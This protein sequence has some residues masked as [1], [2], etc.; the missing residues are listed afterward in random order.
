M[1]LKNVK[2]MIH[3]A[4][5]HFEKIRQ[6]NESL[7]SVNAYEADAARYW[8]DFNVSREF[9]ELLW[10]GIHVDDHIINHFF[11]N[12]LPRHDLK[13]NLDQVLL[14]VVLFAGQYDFDSVPLALWD[15]FPKPKYFTQI[16]CVESGHW[17]QLE[18]REFFEE[19]LI[20]WLEQK[21]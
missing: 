21:I 1:H 16:N 7:G 18:C 6:P 2:S 19:K 4:K 3:N 10:Q 5:K 13:K 20:D 15:S 9:F 12:I 8:K 17:P 11:S 14:P